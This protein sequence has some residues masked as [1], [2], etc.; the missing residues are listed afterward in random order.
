MNDST[1][2]R[3]HKE[4][5][6][7]LFKGRIAFDE[8]LTPYTSARIGG[9]ADC[10][11]KVRTRADLESAAISLWQLSIPFRILGG[12]SNVLISDSGFRGAV[13]L[14]QV[15][16]VEF[17]EEGE[18]ASVF[19]ES[20]AS[21]ASVAK[22]AVERGWSGL[23]WGTMVPGTIGGAIVGN[24]GAHGSDTAGVLL[25]AE[26]LQQEKGVEEWAVDRFKYGY[27]DSELK[28]NPGMVVVLSGRFGL[29]K[30]S[31]EQTRNAALEVLNYRQQTQPPGASWGSM[32]KNP[33]GDH[34]GRLIEAAGLK[35]YRRGAVQISP[36]HANF[37]LNLGEAKATEAWD[38]IQHTRER[39]YEHSGIELELEVE[40]IGEWPPIEWVFQEKKEA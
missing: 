10:L 5:L 23:E 29:N 40:P 16:A 37:F 20:G 38:L 22:R 33:E 32:F 18:K 15:R 14:N 31:V 28:R 9:P 7:R 35:G 1:I 34:A 17:Y 21:L 8:S 30:S 19:A 11:I 26:I 3:E 12:G 25:M 2:N 4:I 36:I 24:A 27:R 13:V 6:E 39:V